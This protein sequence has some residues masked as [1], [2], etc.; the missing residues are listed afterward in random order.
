[1]DQ[2]LS[3]LIPTNRAGDSFSW[4]VGQVEGTARDEKNN[5]GGYRFKVRIIGDH[6][7]SKEILDTPDLPWANVMMPVN[8]PFI[9]GNTG[10]AHPQLKE[11]CWV[12]GFYLD[13][14]KQKPI[15]MGSIGQTPGAT[16]VFNEKIPGDR[17]SFVT[18]VPTS[19]LNTA[20]DGDPKQKGTG[21]NTATGGLA[22]GSKDGDGN[23]RVNCSPK[24]LAGPKQEQWCQ[25][26]AEKCDEQ[27][28]KSQ[29]NTI[30]GEFLYQVQNNNGAIG[31]YVV[32][33]ATGALNE[34]VGI[35]RKYVNKAMRVVNEFIAKVKGYILQKMK[36][37]VKDLIH[38]LLHPSEEGNA[39]TGVTEWFNNLLKDL[40]CQMADLGDRLEEW[41]TNVLMSYV[42]QIYRSV[43]CQVDELVNGIVSK[44][45]EFMEDILSSVLGPLQDILGA[46]ASPLNILGGAVNFVMNLLGI[47]CSGPN[48]ECSKYK[49]VCTNGGKKDK[50]DDKDFLDD[51]LGD[52]DNLFGDTP[53]DYTQYVCDEA[54][55]GKPLDITTVGFVG[56]VPLPGG[57][58]NTGGPGENTKK[59]DK[60]VYNI[61]D[62][63]VTEGQDAEVLV[64]RYGSTQY[65]SSV[66][67]KTLKNLGTA[68]PGEDY[69]EVED[70]LGFAPGETE[71]VITVKT[72]YSEESEPPE[73]FYIQMT[74]N[75]PGVESGISTKFEKNIGKVTIVKVVKTEKGNPYPVKPVNPINEI[76]KVFPPEDTDIPSD[77]PEVPDG[78]FG[79]DYPSY[80]V[81]A[82]RSICPEGDFIVY[83]ITATN[84]EEGTI[85]YY[86]LSGGG[87]TSDDIIGGEMAGSFVIS[88]GTAKVTIGIEDDGV[89]EDDEILTF[90][91]NT[92]GA[93]V[94]VTIIPKTQKNDEDDYDESDDPDDI[95]FEPFVPPTVDPGKI[96]TDPGGGIIEIP[97]DN[98]GD[99]WAEPPYVFITG[100][101]VGATGT[102]LLD[103][104]GFL[105][106]IR[107]KTPG[108]GYKINRPQDNGVRCIID[109]FT[110]I[111][112]GANYD[113]IPDVYIDGELGIAEAIINEDG[114]VIGARMLD[115]T[116][117]FDSFPKIQIVGGNGYGAKLL[118]SLVCLDTQDLST[119]G[120]TK[121]G[122]GRY[123]DCP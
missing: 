45:N 109:S 108:Y 122:T 114:F 63:E 104:N 57:N 85:G 84:V 13:N 106:E 96:I 68:T 18:A 59:K 49:E 20:N 107:I 26:M 120:A 62:T 25:A 94:N 88:G 64:T 46:I 28:M 79:K 81:V 14:D 75:T 60:I 5:K 91:V 55:T 103:Q 95:V 74:K 110:L 19:E 116:R 51:L 8:V 7:E 105:T 113:S 34:G 119:R 93:F 99:P 71:K 54:Y 9:P 102:A 36:N 12:I 52:I 98:P 117:T 39:L 67:Y 61:Q 78:S 80:K 100:E 32:N 83:T 41:L 66:K 29:M 112:P 27:D 72:F 76:D 40:G 17:K 30:M 92:T 118:P 22:D 35:A 58:Q 87:I 24:M 121:I 73:D 53:A 82:N 21:K 123:V 97:I 70:I 16:S 86:T 56:G 43:I 69:L 115:R 4:W 77:S 33:K 47:S 90:S 42:Q 10:G 111:R 23:E 31:T 50:D 2:V 37:G 101:G 48:R 11:G 6:P 38:A 65:S 15:I 89:V 1:M 44:I 3:H